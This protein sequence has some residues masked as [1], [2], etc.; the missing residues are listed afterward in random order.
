MWTCFHLTIVAV[1]RHC[2]I[3]CVL[4]CVC[5]CVCSLSYTAYNARGPFNIVICGLSI[6]TIF[7]FIISH[8]A[9]FSWEKFAEHE[10]CASI[11]FTAF[12][13]NI[14]I[15]KRNERGM[16]KNVYWY[17]FEVADIPVRFQWIMNFLDIFR[18]NIYIGFKLHENR[19]RGNRVDPSEWTDGQTWRS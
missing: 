9:R 7:F 3:F 2:Y 5:V 10:M 6:S 15:I 8:T 18:K 12:V 17:W 4:V 11:F 13:W 19:S 14:F 1:G 16:I